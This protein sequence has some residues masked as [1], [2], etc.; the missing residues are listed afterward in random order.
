MC[1][2]CQIAQVSS[3]PGVD[4][5]PEIAAVVSVP[6]L[7]RCEGVILVCTRRY[8]FWDLQFR[9]ELLEAVSHTEREEGDELYTTRL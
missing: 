6:A 1:G 4:A 2:M 3:A 5:T 7:F 9:C 8:R